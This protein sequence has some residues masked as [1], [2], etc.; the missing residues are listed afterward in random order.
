MYIYVVQQIL[1]DAGQYAI[2]FGKSDAAFQSGPA[3][4]V[5]RCI[6]FIFWLRI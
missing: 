1:T 5:T 6:S 4:M 3:K 2:R